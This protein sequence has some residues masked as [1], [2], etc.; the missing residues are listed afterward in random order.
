MVVDD[1][2]LFEVVEE[3][4]RGSELGA[5]VTHVSAED[6][7]GFG[8]SQ[9]VDCPFEGLSSWATIGASAFDT[10]VTTA[11]GRPLRVEFVVAVDGRF[12]F[13]AS[14]LAGCVGQLGG[15]NAVGPGVVYR[16][17]ISHY[18]PDAT[19]PHLLSLYPWSWGSFPS[20]D[21]AEVYVSW[22]QLVP[23]TDQ[24]MQMVMLGGVDSFEELLLREQPDLYSLDRPSVVDEKRL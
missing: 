8:V 15:V 19:T 16:G 7:W 11:D 12:N 17:A 3:A 1:W 2:E 20:I 5:P 23:V 4:F 18:Y 24:E 14:S 10:G 22:L 21:K 13:L 6:N 9:A